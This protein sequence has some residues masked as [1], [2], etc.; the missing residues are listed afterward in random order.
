M[1]DIYIVKR[2]LED[3][4]LSDRA[5]CIWAALQPFSHNKMD[6]LFSIDYIGYL[7]YGK[8]PSRKESMKV[9]DGFDEL[10]SSGFIKINQKIGKNEFLCD[11]TGLYFERG[12]EY[13]VVITSDELNTIMNLDTKTDKFQLFRY[14]VSLVGCFNHSSKLEEE[15]KGKVCGIALNNVNSLIN[16]RTAIRYNELLEQNHIIYV[17]RFEDILLSKTFDNE[18]TRIPN[19][20][21]RYKDKDNCIKFAIHYQNNYGWNNLKERKTSDI[22]NANKSRGLAQKY[23]ALCRGKAYD[24]KTIKEIYEWAINWNKKQKTLYDEEISKG[25]TPEL[26]EKDLSIFDEYIKNKEEVA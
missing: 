14:F 22:A 9:Q 4:R 10:V 17:F 23:T 25:N 21:S 5:F 15:Y 16:K 19:A 8:M 3:K 18:I 20:Y 11:V 7:L 1:R 26:L 6:L 2:I 24:L 13:F 12:S